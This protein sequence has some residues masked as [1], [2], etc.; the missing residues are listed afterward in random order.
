MRKI[1]FLSFI[2]LILA[3]GSLYALSQFVEPVE[4][5]IGLP[6]VSASIFPV[7][8]MIQIVGKDVVEPHLIIPPGASPHTFEPSPQ[9]MKNIEKSSQIFLIGHG[10]DNWIHDFVANK[11]RMVFLDRDIRIRKSIQH[12]EEEKEEENEPNDPH[13]WLDVKNAKMMVKTIAASLRQIAPEKTKQIQSNTDAYL[14]QLDAL[15]QEMTDQLTLIKNKQLITFH[16]A[17]YY[18]AEAYGFTVLATFEP[19]A[20]REP[21][22]QY[23]ANLSEQISKTG[24]KVLYAEPQF[25]ERTLKAFL[26]DQQMHLA[27][28]DPIGGFDGKESYINLM[29]SNA[30]IIAQYQ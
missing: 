12:D 16:D 17:W 27:V 5:T 24:M 2:L 6:T 20:G 10:L 22:P 9:N 13:Y 15:D 30:D 19:Y 11:D 21:T 18:F 25:S 8:D 3:M 23:L 28:I 7:Y 26:T 4:K 29:K 14:E 1:V